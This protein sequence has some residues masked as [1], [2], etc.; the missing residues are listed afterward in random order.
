MLLTHH[1]LRGKWR[2]KILFII[3]DNTLRFGEIK[4][5][6]GDI[7]DSYLSKILK[8]L[9]SE[10]ILTKKIY[11]V[12]PPKTEYQLTSLGTHLVEVMHAMEV[13]GKSYRKSRSTD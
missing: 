12:M 8:E 13:W 9:E 5:G 11:N 10:G 7:Q 1:M 4:E 3:C 2:I 6:V